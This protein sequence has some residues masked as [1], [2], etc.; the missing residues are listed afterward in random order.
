MDPLVRYYLHQAG[1]G[2][3]DSG[4][5]PIYST[6]PFLQRGHGILGLLGGICRSYVH[7]LRWQDVKAVGS[8]AMDT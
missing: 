4:I 5:G 8:E 6:P 1:R 7:A 2:R 3:A